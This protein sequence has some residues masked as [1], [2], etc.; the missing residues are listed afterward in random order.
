MNYFLLKQYAQSDQTIRTK[1]TLDEVTLFSEDDP[2]NG[3]AHRCPAKEF[4][5]PYFE[6][7]NLLEKYFIVSLEMKNVLLEYEPSLLTRACALKCDDGKSAGYYLIKQPEID[8]LHVDT[9]I[10]GQNVTK[11]V[12]SKESLGKASVFTAVGI[13]AKYLFCS[14]Q[15]LENLLE[16]EIYPFDFMKIEIH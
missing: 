7:S 13:L 9:V 10:R 6:A 2:I 12:F 4:L 15:V 16:K 11:F 14:E 1:E 8:C 5:L 3:I